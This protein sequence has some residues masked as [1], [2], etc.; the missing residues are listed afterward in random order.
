MTGDKEMDRE[1]ERG[2][3]RQRER[4]EIIACPYGPDSISDTQ[5]SQ[6]EALKQCT[7]YA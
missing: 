2:R 1:R 6:V 7:T 3:G 5:Y 4:Y